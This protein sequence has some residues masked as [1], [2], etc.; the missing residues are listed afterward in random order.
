MDTAIAEKI[1]MVDGMVKLGLE[2]I[3]SYGRGETPDED[4]AYVQACLDLQAAY[5]AEE[6]AQRDWRAA[7]AR[8]EE[9]EQAKH[10]AVH[11]IYLAAGA[12]GLDVNV[13]CGRGNEIA[14][15]KAS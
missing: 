12:A 4:V 6:R 5:R 15:Q 1:R 13:E 10:R 8:L 3:A 9:S 2:R 11:A 7:A 14:Q